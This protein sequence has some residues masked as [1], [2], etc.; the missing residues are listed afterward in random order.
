MLSKNIFYPLFLLLIPLI[1]MIFTNEVKWSLYDFLIM[2][3]M[4]FCFSISINK[5]L[6]K[7]KSKMK[8]VYVFS[9]VIIFILLWIEIA[10]GI[11]DSPISG[12]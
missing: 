9:V 3:V 1:S 12:S 5:I 2:G 6:S 10:V 11:F 7:S 8:Y 4:I